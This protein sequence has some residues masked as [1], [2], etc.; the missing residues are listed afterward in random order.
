MEC[1]TDL[2]KRWRC[3]GEEKVGNGGFD[4]GRGKVDEGEDHGNGCDIGGAGD[5]GRGGDGGSH[6]GEVVVGAAGR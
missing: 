1:I 4:G 6:G 5:G 3:G 2:G